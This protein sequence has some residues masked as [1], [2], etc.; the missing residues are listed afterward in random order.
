[1]IGS[2]YVKSHDISCHQL[3]DPIRKPRHIL[4]FKQMYSFHR[5]K[6]TKDGSLNFYQSSQLINYEIYLF[7][8]ILKILK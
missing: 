7:L 4:E 6:G 5:F 3:P 2:N 8:I 1:M